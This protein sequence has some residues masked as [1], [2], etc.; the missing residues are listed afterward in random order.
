MPGLVK[1]GRTIRDPSKRATELSSTTG[2]PIPFVLIYS[3]RVKDQVEAETYAHTMLSQSGTRESNQRE[4]FRIELSKAINVL[5]QIE[6]LFGEEDNSSLNVE[7]EIETYLQHGKN[8]YFGENEVIPDK[9]DALNWF[10]KASKLNSGEAN[11]YIAV[12]YQELEKTKESLKYAKLGYNLGFERCLVPMSFAYF[13]LNQFGSCLAACKLY[14]KS[15][16]FLE[17]A[18][19]RLEIAQYYYMNSLRLPH[20]S[21][22]VETFVSTFEPYIDQLIDDMFASQRLIASFGDSEGCKNVVRR[23]WGMLQRYYNYVRQDYFG[24]LKFEH[25][26]DSKTN[27]YIIRSDGEKYHRYNFDRSDFVGKFDSSG[28]KVQYDLSTDIGVIFFVGRTSLDADHA[29]VVEVVTYPD[30]KP[31]LFMRNPT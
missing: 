8:C 20:T 19:S 29:Y 6:K 25:L 11:Y 26:S 22:D 9:E 10:L 7:K 23:D 24:F 12:I 1:V 2:V 17:N 13:E 5:V 28:L 4:F 27:Y 16:D 18:E 15:K 14:F 3:V 30:G 31:I 21:D